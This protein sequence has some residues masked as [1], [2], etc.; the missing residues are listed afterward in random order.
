LSRYLQETVGVDFEGGDQLGLTAEHWRNAVKLEFAEQAVVA[1]LSTL[2]LVAVIVERSE[3][4][5]TR[6]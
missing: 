3:N 2:T 4:K 6:R 5:N 1:A